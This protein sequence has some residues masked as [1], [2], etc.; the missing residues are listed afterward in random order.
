MTSSWHPAINGIQQGSLVEIFGISDAGK[1]SLNGQK[2]QLVDYA[3]GKFEIVLIKSGDVVQ[4]DPRF[5]RACTDL[6][7]PGL[8]GDEDSF[9]IIIGPK[10]DRDVL[11]QEIASCLSE[12]GFSVVKHIQEPSSLAA[13][14]QTLKEAEENGRFGR[15]AK[16]LEEGYLGK[17]G[18]A[19]VMWLNPECGNESETHDWIYRCDYNMMTIAELLQPFCEDSV[20][21]AVEERTP[22]LICSTMTDEEEE[23]QYARTPADEHSLLDFYNTWSRSVLRVVQFLGPAIGSVSLAPKADSPLEH[24]LPEYTIAA[25]P[26][27][28]LIVR[29]DTFDYFYD[30]PFDGESSWMQCFLLCP[31]PSWDL[32]E[33]EEGMMADMVLNRKEE[34]PPPPEDNLV[35]V[36][37]CHLQAAGN[38]NGT[39]FEWNSYLAGCDGQL[40]MPYKRFEYAEYYTTEM[41]NC[42]PGHTYVKHF[43]VMEGIELFDNK[44]FEISVAEAAAIDP[45]NRQ[46]MEVGAVCLYKIGLTKKEA[47]K[48]MTHASVSVGLDKNEWQYMPD[49]PSSVA[50]NNQLA[51]AA[52][53]FNYVFNLKGG[54]YVC[55]T[56]CSSSLVAA[57]LGK[58]NMLERR[59][60]P[61]EF[62]LACG[63]NLTLTVMSF[64]NS[65]QAHMLSNHGR[66]LTFN[67]TANGYNR[68]DGC[69]GLLLMCGKQ[70]ENRICYLR[71]SQIGNDGRSASMSAP[72]GPAQEKCIWGAIREACMSAPESTVWECHGT[73]T[74]LGD[75]IEVGAVRKVQI[76][77]PRMEPLMIATSKSNIGHLEGGAAA[78]AM[79][80]CCMVVYHTKAL[81]TIHFRSLNP[82]LDH[83]MFDAIFTT[84][85][86]NYK[87]RQGHCQV[88]SFGV[89]GTNGHA[90]FWGEDHL[91][92]HSIDY[93]SLFMKK[94]ES[95]KPVLI[96]NGP[97]PADWDFTGP[98][99]RSKPGD[100]YS[101]IMEKDSI[102]GNTQFR[103]EKDVNRDPEPEFYATTG[104]H[105]AWSA[106]RMS[107]GDVPHL[108]AQ[109]I[110]MPASRTI[111]FRFLVEGDSNR[112]LGPIE[113][114]CTRRTTPLDVARSDCTTSWVVNGEPGNRVRIELFAPPSAPPSVNWFIAS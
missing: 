23:L 21:S 58:V 103:W 72:N 51:I 61:L 34:G 75:P 68:G 47:N 52:N 60:D 49:V 81:P 4:L 104:T 46:V 42:P 24:L 82:H 8:D 67:D 96:P 106:D 59:W 16:E 37:A 6:K 50:A 65:C 45:Q 95:F 18:R 43:S 10:T 87:Y 89:G 32:G 105:N 15:L 19:K 30:D 40:E 91:S 5:V 102:T 13:A 98:D 113:A 73:G 88:S 28:L 101:I 55:D 54:S 63:V 97:N 27:T 108:Y 33:F 100:K 99:F 107:Q 76:K 74:A 85:C 64:V 114:A 83:A 94:L 78:I 41:D 57:H 56:A 2:G 110:T 17:S 70:D 90:I 7:R 53:R 77:Q 22:S 111:E 29:E 66:C 38:M 86:C 25:S 20:G 92:K 26:G 3:D 62:H 79:V 112:A 9:D 48:K 11:G 80:K 1:K 109:E 36:T 39:A 84:E 69:G 71:G 93:K 35:A 44:A 31:A 14:L 12:K